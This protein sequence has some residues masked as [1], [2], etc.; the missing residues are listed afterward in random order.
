MEKNLKIILKCS[1]G[2]VREVGSYLLLWEHLMKL[3]GEL[4][5]DLVAQVVHKRLTE[6]SITVIFEVYRI[7]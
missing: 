6:N 7:I 1:N 3:F 4:V 5:R 2:C